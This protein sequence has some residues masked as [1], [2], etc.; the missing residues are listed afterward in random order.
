[1]QNNNS[2]KNLKQAAIENVLIWMLLFIGFIGIFFLIIDYATIVRIQDKMNELGDYAAN[3]IANDGA[4]MDLTAEFNN[5]K[6]AAIQTF[7][8][9]DVNTTIICS[10]VADGLYQV[11]FN[12]VTTN[13]SYKFYNN[14]LSSSKVVFNNV[15]I[16]DANVANDSDSIECNL[17]ITLVN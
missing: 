16:N 9:N 7:N 5:R 4:I 8:A 6:V 15:Y 13:N 11:R 3:R 14:P 12:I 17:Q 10:D 2:N 1:M